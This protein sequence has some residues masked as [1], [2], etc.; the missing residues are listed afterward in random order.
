MRVVSVGSFCGIAL[1]ST[2]VIAEPATQGFLYGLGVGVNQEI[3]RGYKKRVIPIPVLG[4]KG[5]RLTI[6]GPFITYD[7]IKYGNF[8]VTGQVVPRFAGFDASDSHYFSGM[9][10]RKNSIDSGIG[11]S[12]RQDNLLFEVST[13]FDVLSHSNGFSATTAISYG[14]LFGAVRFEPKFSVSYQ[15]SKLVDYYFGVRDNEA[16]ASRVAYRGTG[17]INYAASLAMSTPLF[18]KGMSRLG[19]KHT[20]YGS[21][22]RNSPL[23]DRETGFSL[24]ASWSRMF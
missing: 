18:F 19:V 10:K 7:L 8:T 22:I 12:L 3:Y 20:W 24:F 2:P 14:Q 23:T 15:D 4:Y 13:L 16:T 11:V 9:A 1:L 17:S 5:D 21:G 6:F